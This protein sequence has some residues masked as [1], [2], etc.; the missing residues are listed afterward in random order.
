MKTYKPNGYGAVSPYLIVS[1]A[2]ATIEFLK[3]VFGGVELRR[4][5]NEQN[6]GKVN[7]AEVRVDD[8]VI[9]I[10]DAAPPAWPAVPGHAYVYVPDVDETYRKALATGATS[11]QEP[12]QKGDEDRRGGVRDVGGTTWWIA[13]RVG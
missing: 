11:V 1:D 6:A 5:P 7:H 13:T 4:F 2:N 9:M 10:A 3:T 8:T 12:V